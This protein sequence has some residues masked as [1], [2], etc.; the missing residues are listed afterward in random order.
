MPAS[1]KQPDERVGPMVLQG[2]GDLLEVVVLSGLTCENWP[3]RRSDLQRSTFPS[4]SPCSPY[5]QP[6][7]PSRPPT[8]PHSPQIPPAEVACG[9]GL[10]PDGIVIS[11]AGMA[12][13]RSKRDGTTWRSPSL[14][15]SESRLDEEAASL[16][17]M[18]LSDLLP[19]LLWCTRGAVGAASHSRGAP[20]L[21]AT[22]L[23]GRTPQSWRRGRSRAGR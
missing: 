12:T 19:P 13:Q 7:P 18:S 16:W 14:T 21:T 9:G 1:G 15:V 2:R 6:I 20:V 23:K 3:L 8:R 22:Q 10:P 5:M 11:A 17:A 4:L